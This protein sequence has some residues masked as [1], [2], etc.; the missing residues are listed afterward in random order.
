[1]ISSDPRNDGLQYTGLSL[2]SRCHLFSTFKLM[3]HFVVVVLLKK[4]NNKGIWT[5][6]DVTVP[7]TVV[8]RDGK[9]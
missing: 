5:V 8:Y 1:M 3:C 9:L 4:E 7:I 2:L 6:Y